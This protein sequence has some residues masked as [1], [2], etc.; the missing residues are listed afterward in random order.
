MKRTMWIGSLAALLVIA[1]LSASVFAQGRGGQGN[2]GVC[3]FGYS[4][5]NL[6]AGGWWTRVQAQTPEQQAFLDEA[7]RLHNQIRSAYFE[8]AQL[9]DPELIAAKQAEI[10]ALRDDLHDLQFNNRA[11]KQELVQTMGRGGRG[12]R[13]AWSGQAGRGMRGGRGFGRGTGICPYGSGPGN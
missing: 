3:P 5:P 9:T 11:L 1:G 6:P 7:T 4:Q 8:L 12:C 10:S 2:A 13:G